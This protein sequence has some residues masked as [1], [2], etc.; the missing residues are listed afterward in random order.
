MVM[1]NLGCITHGAAM[2]YPG[3]GFEPLAVLETVEAE[4]CTALYGVPTM[5]IA[6]LNHPDFE[7]FDLSSLRTGCMAGA[8]CPIEVMRRCIDDMHMR[9]VTIA[10]GMTETSPVSFQTSTDD[11]VERKI[12]HHRPHSPPCRGEDRRYRAVASCRPARR[13]SCAPA[14]IA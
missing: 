8:P 4:Q 2:V 7:R 5:F 6:E 11:S 14:A 9:D 10:Y 3:E 1:G 12:Q 13:A